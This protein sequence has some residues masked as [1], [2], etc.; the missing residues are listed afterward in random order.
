MKG[1]NSMK[2]YEIPTVAVLLFSEN[3]ILTSSDNFGDDI[4]L[5]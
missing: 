1:E 4:F 3:D 2:L 5:D